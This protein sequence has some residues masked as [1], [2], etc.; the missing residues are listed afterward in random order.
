MIGFRYHLVSLV[1]VFLALAVGVGVGSTALRGPIVDDLGSNVNRLSTQNKAL[2]GD[3]ADLR[4]QNKR[5]EQFA[6]QAAPRLL[7]GVLA[8]QRIA[9]IS[10]PG[11]PTG[12]RDAVTK[13]LNLAGAHVVSS[14]SLTGEFTDPSNAAKIADLSVRDLD[15]LPGLQLPTAGGAVAQASALVG[16]ALVGSPGV[17]V[18]GDARSGILQSFTTLGIATVRGAV[19]A[20][21]TG[22]VVI[23]GPAATGANAKQRD[24]AL[25]T[26]V[27]QLAK[28]TSR[29]VLSGPSS[30]GA[31]TVA[32]VRTDHGLAKTLSTVDDVEQPTGQVATALALAAETKGHSG[33]YGTQPGAT[34]LLPN[35]T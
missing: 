11:A 15:L 34:A 3:V 20:M 25:V 2:R 26:V 5:Q 23:G 31:G 21:A 30:G 27:R 6:T 28:S 7:K 17:T 33:H 10:L 16:A 35:Q 24:S 9:V 1:A 12:S 18:T 14:V 29:I 8:G 22:V 19:S 32:A 13:D 4:T